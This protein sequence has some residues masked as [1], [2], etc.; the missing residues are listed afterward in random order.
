MA[1][2]ENGKEKKMVGKKISYDPENDILAIHKGFLKD[3]KFKSNIDT[4]GLVID[5]STKGRVKGIEIMN[6]TRFL[7]GF[8]I[9]KETLTGLTDADFEANAG[10]D[11]IMI[12]LMLKAKDSKATA[13]IAIAMA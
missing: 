8:D 2:D 7:K 5:M 10:K 9:G 3:E 13:K 6:A 11:S 12:S 4:G 1:R